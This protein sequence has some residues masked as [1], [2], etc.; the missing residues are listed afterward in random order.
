MVKNFQRYF[1]FYLASFLFGLLLMG[2]RWQGAPLGAAGL[3]KEPTK[4]G[5]S[6]P[7][8]APA[9]RATVAFR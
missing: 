1:R 7:R 2:I 8:P 4:T 6:A 9:G 3:E 5:A